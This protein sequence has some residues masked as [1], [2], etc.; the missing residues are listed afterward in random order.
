MRFSFP[1]L[2][3][4]REHTADI[5]TMAARRAA[6]MRGHGRSILSSTEGEESWCHKIMRENTTH[7]QN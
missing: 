4:M 7:L 1:P 2:T 5:T 6:L 3:W